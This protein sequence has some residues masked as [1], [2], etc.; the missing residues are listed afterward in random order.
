VQDDVSKVPA[1]LFGLVRVL[2]DETNLLIRESGGV[3]I[4]LVIEFTGHG[5][6]VFQRDAGELLGEGLA[7]LN[8]GREVNR[9]ISE[10]HRFP[11]SDR[12]G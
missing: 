9:K 7:P 12:R 4:E 8:D 2:G 6:D 10:V 11:L 5:A 1:R 3:G